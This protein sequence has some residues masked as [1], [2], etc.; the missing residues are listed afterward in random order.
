LAKYYAYGIRNSFGF[1]FDPIT[2]KLW[3]A[4]NGQD[5]YNEIN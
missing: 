1:D 4:E 2:A 3:D 5:L